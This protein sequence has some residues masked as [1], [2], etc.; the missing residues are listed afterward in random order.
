M[1]IREIRR[2]IANEYA[3]PGQVSADK[4]AVKLDNITNYIGHYVTSAGLEFCVSE[5]KEGL[6]LAYEGQPPLFIYPASLV[7]FF[8]PA[9]NVVVRFELDNS[10]HASALVILQNGN[11]M[12]AYRAELN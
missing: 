7:E 2:A 9:L 1:I 8:T 6:T 12:K 11:Q 5:A 3:W 10:A 4:K